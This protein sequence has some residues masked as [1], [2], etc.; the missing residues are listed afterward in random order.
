M[1]INRLIFVT[2]FYRINVKAKFISLKIYTFIRN[3]DFILK[4]SDLCDII[5]ALTL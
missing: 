2:L 3:N 1:L 5:S 4:K